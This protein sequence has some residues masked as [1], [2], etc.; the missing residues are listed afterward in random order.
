MPHVV[1]DTCITC[2]ACAEN[3]PVEAIHTSDTASQ[4][5][6]DPSV[7]I[8]CGACKAT[9]PTDSIFPDDDVPADREHSIKENAE[10]YK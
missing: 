7:C 5:C 10:F 2:G 1:T 9:C 6:I 3:C 8:D 4:Y